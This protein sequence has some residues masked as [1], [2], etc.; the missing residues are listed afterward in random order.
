[1]VKRLAVALLLV[2]ALLLGAYCDGRE[3]KG[4][5]RAAMRRAGG[6][7]EIH[8]EEDKDIGILFSIAIQSNSGNN[9]NGSLLLLKLVLVLPV[10]TAGVERKPQLTVSVLILHNCKGNWKQ[11]VFAISGNSGENGALI[12]LAK[13]C[14]VHSQNGTAVGEALDCRAKYPEDSIKN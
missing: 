9:R 1:M 12:L 3:L 7:L 8:D 5:N 4:S 2:A 10:A 14:T 6:E 13:E 11:L